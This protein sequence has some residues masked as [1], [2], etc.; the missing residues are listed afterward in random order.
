MTLEPPRDGVE[1][2]RMDANLNLPQEIMMRKL[3]G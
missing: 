2:M 3:R 1:T